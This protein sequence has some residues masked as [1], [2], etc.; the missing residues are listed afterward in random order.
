MD[1]QRDIFGIRTH[2]DGQTDFTQQFTTVG[3]DDRT[4]D[5]TVS[6]FV[7]N[8]FG[9]TVSAVG[10]DCTTG[11][12]PWEHGSF[13]VD[14]FGFR[15]F[16]G[17]THPCDFRFGIRDRRDHFRIEVMFLASD[18]FGSNVTFVHT[19]VRQH[20]LTHDV[21]DREN[22]RYVSTKLFIHFDETT[23]G[24]SD[25]SFLGIQRFTVWYSAYRYQHTVITNR[26]CR[27]L[28]AFE[29]DIQT[30]FFRFNGSY[31]GFQHHV[32]FLLNTFCVNLH[33]VFIG[34]RNQLIR[35]FNHV[36]FGTQ[37]RVHS[38]HFQ[39]DDTTAQNQQFARNFFQFQ[40]IGRVPYAW[41]VVRN[42]RQ[43]YRT[44]TRRDNRVIKLNGRHRAISGS[45]VNAVRA[46]ELGDTVHHRYFALFGHAR[47][48]AGQL[49][50]YFFFPQTDLVDISLRFT[51]YDTVFCQCF[52]FFDNFG[53]VQQCFRRNTTD[54][55]TDTTQCTVAFDQNSFQAQVGSTES[56]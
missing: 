28:F 47:Q 4:T 25:T 9:H 53:Y 30:V 52:G 33:H 7:E 42:E 12:C 36:D 50:H 18:N 34:N 10:G 19:F 17:Q 5:H 3:T 49:G 8:Q 32:E 23:F 54:V 27:C 24:H 43:F 56:G 46:G 41:I 21:T 51:E 39:T 26:F 15:F 45:H 35:E 40:R 44:G 38:T 1:S 37:C 29:R 6:G 20:W 22:V 16:L 14:A 11:C 55:Q 13:K 2:F 31:F 48:T